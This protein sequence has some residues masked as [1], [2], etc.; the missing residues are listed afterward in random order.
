MTAHTLLLGL[1]DPDTLSK[2]D[3]VTNGDAGKDTQT[4]EGER[5]LL[6]F[7]D[8]VVARDT[9][10]SRVTGEAIIEA[11]GPEQLVDAAAVVA[12]FDAINRVADAAG[13]ELDKSMQG[14]TTDLRNHL[15]FNA[16]N[17]H[18]D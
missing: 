12:H 10:Q 4:V 2:L 14:V 6:A 15:G 18:A 11:L 1:S 13:I 7:A 3:I 5:E 16:F 8:A 9:E 17:T